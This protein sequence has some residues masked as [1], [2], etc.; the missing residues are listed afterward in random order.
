MHKTLEKRILI[1]DNNIMSEIF[2]ELDDNIRIIEN[3]LDI[4][5]IIGDGEIKLL[6][7]EISLIAADRLIY[8]LIDIIMI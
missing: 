2:G 1:E 3:E 5:V 6:G 4:K 7:N 8:N